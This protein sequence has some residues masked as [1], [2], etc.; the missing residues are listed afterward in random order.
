MQRKEA[1]FAHLA[2]VFIILVAVVGAAGVFVYNRNKSETSSTQ[3]ST[4]E[5]STISEQGNDCTE[6]KAGGFTDYLT[7]MNLVTTIQNPIRLIGG[8]NIKTHAYI[9]VSE[10]AP[11]YAP[12]DTTLNG[13]ANYYET[14]GENPVTKVQYLLAFDNGCDVQF[15]LDH[16]VDVPDKIKNAFPSEARNDTQAV[17]VTETKI[18]AGEM[19]GYTNQTGRTRF[20][21][22]VLNLKGP[23]TSLTT[24]PKYKDDP[25]VKT[26]DKYRYAIC[27]FSLYDTAKLEKYKSFYDP[28]TNS[29]QTIIDNICD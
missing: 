26:S 25:I 14:M 2:V 13:G 10:R 24:N 22:G 9:E 1:G 21:F 12:T 4:N 5:T 16:I 17:D 23:L 7:D 11:V 18:S 27:P 28:N 20:D 29:D 8:S 6:A 19:V 3:N 15:W